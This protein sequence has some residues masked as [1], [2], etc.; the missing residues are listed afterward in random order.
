MYSE[1]ATDPKVQMLSE[2]DQRRYLMLLCLRCCNGDVTLQDAECAFQMRISDAEYA[3]TKALLIAR[4][5]IDEANQP[6]AWERRQYVS[7]TSNSRVSRYR[8]RKR[9]DEKKACN[10]T[11]TPPETDTDTEL[12]AEKKK[13]SCVVLPLR[14]T[15]RRDCSTEELDSRFEEFWEAFPKGR[16][17]GKGKAKAL[18]RQI[19][20]GGHHSL[21][22]SAETLIAAAKAYAAVAPDPQ[23]T[24]MPQTWLAGGR[25]DDD[26]EQI[27]AQ[28]KPTFAKPSRIL[29]AIA[30]RSAAV[31]AV[32]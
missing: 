4:G 30:R 3:Q 17:K 15:T 25:W 21:R 8:E 23:Y 28:A 20:R 9:K 14:A 12:E 10:V 22:A 29:E 13:E 32:Q 11:V 5:L 7:D 1:F 19:A 31:E 26:L 2:A 6:L 18:F 16:K 27:A 24:P